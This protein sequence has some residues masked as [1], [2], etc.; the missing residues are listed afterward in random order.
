M[1]FAE[2]CAIDA[3]N[4]STLSA[5]RDSPHHYRHAVTHGRKDTPTLARGRYVHTAIL[6]PDQL[7]TDYAIYDGKRR[8]GNDYAA[9]VAANE[10][11]TV[12]KASELEEI[13]P[14]IE[15]VRNHPDARA[16]LDLDGNE[17]ETPAVW[18]DAATGL[19]CKARTDL[20][21]RNRKIVVDLKTSRSVDAR[22]FGHEL[23]RY[24][25]HHQLAHYA[26]GIAAA[27]GWTPE[28][29]ILI[30]V[31]SGAPHDVAVFPIA[32]PVIEIGRAMVANLLAAVA[33]CRTT[34]K[35]PG[36]Y[37]SPVPLDETNLPPWV[38]GGGVPEFAF[39]E[40]E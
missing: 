2:Y 6:Q 20:R 26:A 7:G 34:G 5:M 3:I 9:F 13:Q 30:V 25:Y 8:A 12:F 19:R 27:D 36:R 15:A 33:E 37:T 23:E 24:G 28:Q 11:K 22:R 16:I 31:E 21:N 29:H 17:Y 35:W 10:G 32:E 1:T 40:A 14:I 18:T 39:V 38:F 4:W